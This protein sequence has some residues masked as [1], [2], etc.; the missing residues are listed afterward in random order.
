M[1]AARILKNKWFSKYA[2]RRGITD[3]V[4]VNAIRNA[5]IGL[6]DADLGGGLLKLRL[7]REGKGKS[8]GFRVLVV[9]KQGDFAIALYAFAKSEKANLTDGELAEYKLAAK[10]IL[11]LTAKVVDE[12]VRIGRL[13]E[14]RYEQE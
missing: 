3:S 1:K 7:P 6:V 12:W 13:V 5:E 14:V 9:L 2:T 8:G 10:L 4:L 11:D